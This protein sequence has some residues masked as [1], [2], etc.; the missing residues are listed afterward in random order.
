MSSQRRMRQMVLAGGWWSPA[1]PAVS[2]GARTRPAAAART[3]PAPAARAP[4]RAARA[5][6]PAARAPGAPAARAP[7]ARAPG[8]GRHGGAGT[9]GA[10]AARAGAERA[11]AA[12][13]AVAAGRPSHPCGN[14]NPDP[15]VCGR[16]DASASNA[17]L[18]DQKMTCQRIGGVWTYSPGKCNIDLDAG[19]D[20]RRD[21]RRAPT[22]MCAIADADR[23]KKFASG[24]APSRGRGSSHIRRPRSRSRATLGRCARPR[25]SGRR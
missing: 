21:A 17:A 10:A 15:C 19:V 1:V 14:P 24:C 16:P 22:V 18:C 13:R 12:V 11:A 2:W 9:G 20:A 6:A 8:G 3:F 7:G 23:R 25:S 4:V 5:P